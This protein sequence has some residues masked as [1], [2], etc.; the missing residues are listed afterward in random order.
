MEQL[1]LRSKP[2][3]VLETSSSLVHHLALHL[4][5]HPGHHLYLQ[6]QPHQH[7][8][9]DS[10]NVLSAD[11]MEELR[12]K[13]IDSIKRMQKFA[14]NMGMALNVSKTEF[15]YFGAKKMPDIKVGDI[16]MA[17]RHEGRG[18]PSPLMRGSNMVDNTIL[19]F[20]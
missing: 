11:T 1:V 10:T 2:S 3:F 16:D 19:D 14:E 20:I 6:N 4:V 17:E 7:Y 13:M 5:R 8:A 18:Y 12:E 9:D 15:I